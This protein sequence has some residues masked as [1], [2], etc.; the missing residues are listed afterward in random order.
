M[1]DRIKEIDKHIA[2]IRAEAEQI[3]EKIAELKGSMAD[4]MLK[5]KV[6]PQTKQKIG[7]LK[8][9]REACDDAVAKLNR[10]RERIADRIR[11]EAIERKI[12]EIEAEGPRVV[13]EF[14]A[15]EEATEEYVD[16]LR[17]F[18][19]RLREFNA[20]CGIPSRRNGSRLAA[21]LQKQIG[22][23][24]RRLLDLP[25]LGNAFLE[26]VSPENTV[27]LIEGT[28]AAQVSRLKDEL[29]GTMI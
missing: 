15:L 28:C 4:G 13:A 11:A 18:D 9:D 22:A 6:N 24:S 14:R 2:D 21:L 26:R 12:G 7:S 27:R 17:T 25:H 29:K 19:R 5:G 16:R 3:E 8:L 23:G 20:L 1:E 10:E